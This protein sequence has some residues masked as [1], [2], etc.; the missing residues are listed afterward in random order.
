[1]TKSGKKTLIITAAKGVRHE[2]WA[3]QLVRHLNWLHGDIPAIDLSRRV[4]W[5]A[6]SCPL[7]VKAHV[8]RLVPEQVERIVWIDVDTYVTRPIYG[9]ELPTYP[10]S[11]VPDPW[12]ATTVADNKDTGEFALYRYLPGYFN[13]GVFVATRDSI[14]AFEW[15]IEQEL[16]LQREDVD[17]F[18][19]QDLLN[20]AVWTMLGGQRHDDPGWHVMDEA[21]NYMHSN[22][23]GSMSDAVVIHL[24]GTKGEEKQREL[25]R[26][27]GPMHRHSQMAR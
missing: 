10:F 16:N 26:L 8:W 27:Y 23:L 5:D 7:M 2:R 17:W 18:R 24:A 22:R 25:A 11:A 12:V 3:A 6:M 21:W 14:P 20:Y 19:E 9:N 1:M 13:S 4:D 15:A